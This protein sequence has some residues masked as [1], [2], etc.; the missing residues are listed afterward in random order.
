MLN[1]NVNCLLSYSTR[2]G[3]RFFIINTFKIF[4]VLTN[5]TQNEIYSQTFLENLK[6]VNKSKHPNSE[7]SQSHFSKSEHFFGQ[8][9]TK[10]MFL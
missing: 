6:L 7:V 4:F 8:Y 3:A 5:L 1:Q 2:G 9:T 10:K